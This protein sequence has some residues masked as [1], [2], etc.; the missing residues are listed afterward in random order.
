MV[1]ALTA[2]FGARH[3][4]LAEEVV[5]EALIRALQLWPYQGIPANPR[6]WLVQVAR[7]LA[8]DRLRRDASFAVKRDEVERRM[9]AT[10][11]SPEPVEEQLA[12]M[13][14]C[15][16]P[17]LPAAAR[18]A[19]TLK[20]AAGFSIGEIA[21]AFLA[22]EETIA[23]RIVRAKRQIREQNLELEMPEG[24]ELRQRLDS[25]LE[26]LYLLFNEGYSASGGDHLLRTDLCEEAVYLTS[27]LTA[28]SHTDL[29]R[30]HALLALQL[31]L[32]ARGEAR[33]DT[34]GDLLVLEEQDRSLWDHAL[35]ARAYH[36]LERSTADEELTAFHLQA[37]IASEHATAS[38]L[39]TT[40]WTHIVWLYDQMLRIRPSP[41]VELNR[42]VAV[43]YRDG[44]QAGMD[45]FV[46]IHPEDPMTGYALWHAVEARLLERLGRSEDASGCYRRALACRLN[47]P[48]RRLLERRLARLQ[49]AT[50]TPR[51][52]SDC[53]AADADS[54]DPHSGS[55]PHA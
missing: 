7:R 41:V 11:A 2:I 42:A 55:A 40:N 50:A 14:L 21:R 20:V 54:S 16:H 18:L 9:T 23:Q 6:A 19:L 44:A 12:L 43:S 52:D 47:A 15:C 24:A 46:S 35:I 29:P 37:L 4:S 49:A 45:A 51:A 32:A 36:H 28:G 8:L 13:F 33:T 25:V 5:Q 3:L 38:S 10:V 31:F 53:A 1:A 39:E 26:A 48:E 22:S 27:L 34:S 30:V 17:A